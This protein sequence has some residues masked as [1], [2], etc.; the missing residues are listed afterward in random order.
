[1]GASIPIPQGVSLYDNIYQAANFQP[2][3]HSPDWLKE[4]WYDP[5]RLNSFYEKVKPG[6]DWDY[7]NKPGGNY[8]NFGNFNYAVTGAAAGIPESVLRPAAGAAQM[9]TAAQNFLD[10]FDKDKFSWSPSWG[11]PVTGWPYG[12]EPKDQNQMDRANYWMMT[13]NPL[14]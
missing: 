13:G 9:Y 10:K 7:K 14:K 2:W 6:G 12:D 1:L 4:K 3:D 11:T 5:G 8:E